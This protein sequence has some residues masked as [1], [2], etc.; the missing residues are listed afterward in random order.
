MYG[1]QTIL[2]F[3]NHVKIETFVEFA[4][5]FFFRGESKHPHR[6][7]VKALEDLLA[8]IS[9][10]VYL[11]PHTYTFLPGTLIATLFLHLMNKLNNIDCQTQ[12]VCQCSW[13]ALY[14][15]SHSHSMETGPNSQCYGSLQTTRNCATVNHILHP[16]LHIHT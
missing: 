3:N 15:L 6:T 9:T 16:L 8:E 12:I 1:E 10:C 13:R 11:T 5:T 7:M 2:P 14:F 4:R